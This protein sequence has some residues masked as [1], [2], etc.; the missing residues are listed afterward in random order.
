[1]NI[2]GD[3]GVPKELTEKHCC[4]E[5]TLGQFLGFGLYVDLR[6]CSHTLE[7][8]IILTFNLVFCK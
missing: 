8:L 1:V 4:S 2:F 7:Y 3:R 5:P 6:L